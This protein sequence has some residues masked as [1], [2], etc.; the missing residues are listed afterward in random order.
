MKPPAIHA[1]KTS[2][3]EPTARAMSLVTRKT[4]VPMVSPMTIAVAD[5][6]PKPRTKS[7]RWWR[8][9]ELSL[10]SARWGLAH[11][12]VQRDYSER[13][14]AS[15]GALHNGSACFFLASPEKRLARNDATGWCEVD[16]IQG[17]C[18][19]SSNAVMASEKSML[20]EL[21]WDQRYGVV[22]IEDVLTPTLVL[23]PQ[24][25][26]ANI[27]RTLELLAGN[28]DRW[29]VHIK[30]AKLG[31]TLRMLVE[32]GVRNFKCA[33]T[34]ELLVA[35]QNGANDVLLC[36]SG[37]GRECAAGA[38]NRGG[39]S[40]RAHFGSGRERRASAAMARQPRR[41]FSRH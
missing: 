39:V 19:V 35:C 16:A 6:R 4:P 30:T 2:V 9:V 41:N 18:A 1:T 23:Y 36:V 26:E 11:T 12:K 24:V 38:G 21:G 22:G 10:C 31:Y 7:G 37:D 33:T 25:I 3:A 40:G 15:T 34:L 28:A 27:E 29:R 5:H 17:A 13:R 20:S 8:S 32:R 14:G